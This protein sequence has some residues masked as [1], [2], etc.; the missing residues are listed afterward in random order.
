MESIKNKNWFHGSESEFQ[1]FEN[2]NPNI[3]GF[4]FSDSKD[5]AATY[6]NKIKTVKLDVKTPLIIDAEGKK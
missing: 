2:K 1:E 6:G 5:N 4:W 3:T